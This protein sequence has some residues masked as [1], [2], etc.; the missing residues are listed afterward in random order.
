MSLCLGYLWLGMAFVILASILLWNG[1]RS[2]SFK[3]S[4]VMVPLVIWYSMALFYVPS[5]LMGWPSNNKMPEKFLVISSWVQEPTKDQK[6]GI[7]FWGLEWEGQK[8]DRKLTSA[9]EAF[10]Y[11]PESMTPRAF[12]VDYSSALQKK[13]TDQEEEVKQI[14]GGIIMVKRVEKKIENEENVERIEP[15]SYLEFTILNPAEV[16]TK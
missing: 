11:L 16:P 1:F 4:L 8:P 12:R 10:R 5:H 7:Y 3:V 9:K 6:G 2:R 15:D 14:S 13:L